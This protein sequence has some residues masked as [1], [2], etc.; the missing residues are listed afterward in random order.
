MNTQLRLIS[1]LF[2]LPLLLLGC[3]AGDEPSKKAKKKRPPRVHLVETVTVEHEPLAYHAERTGSLRAR[4]EVRIFNQE[5]GRVAEL[6]PFEGDRVEAGEVVARLDEGLLRAQLDKAQAQRRQAELDLKRQKGLAKKRL[7]AEDALA[8]A[9]TA[10]QVAQAEEALLR[11]RLGYTRIRA[12]FTGVVTERLAEPGDVAPRH[13]HLLTLM[14]PASLIME[15]RVSE[16]LLPDIRRDDP[17]EMRIDALGEAR[18]HGQIRR[19]HPTV[20]PRTRMGR[21]EIALEPAPEGALPGQLARV[22]LEGRADERLALPFHALR[23]DGD[24]EYVFILGDEGRVERRTVKSGPR[25]AKRVAILEGLNG[26][27]R[28]VTK[29]F[30][31][32]TEATKVKVV[33]GAE[34]AKKGPPDKNQ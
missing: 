23:R 32:L 30:L 9:R 27:E 6:L 16:L 4:R 25:L 26:G 28:V 31:G 10:L 17:V 24:G 1:I 14:D 21:V 2:L 15:A 18:H 3:K 22:R 29:G 19:I 12:P 34:E 13:T 11:T 20:D 7:A 8:R 5:E 33:G